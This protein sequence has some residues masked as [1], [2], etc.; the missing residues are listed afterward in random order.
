MLIAEKIALMLLLGLTKSLSAA[1]LATTAN[2]IQVA[3][4]ERPIPPQLEPIL[5]SMDPGPHSP[6]LHQPRLF[7]Q[8]IGEGLNRQPIGVRSEFAVC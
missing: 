6:H 5:I 3:R 8:Q 7:K 4:L 1:F 2:V